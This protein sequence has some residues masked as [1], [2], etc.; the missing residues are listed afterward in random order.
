MDRYS[1]LNQSADLRTPMKLR[2]P[3]ED[4]R[5][6]PEVMAEQDLE[7]TLQLLAERARYLT[8]ASSASIGL[9][10]GTAVVCRASAGPL[11]LGLGSRLAVDSGLVGESLRQRNIMRID[12][13]EEDSRASAES[14]PELGIRS[15]MVA[16]LVREEEA[17]GVFE[18]LAERAYAFEER[19]VATLQR[20]SEMILT[21]LE[22]FD[23]ASRPLPEASSSKREQTPASET[24]PTVATGTAETSTARAIPASAGPEPQLVSVL[25]VQACQ[26]CGFPVSE[27]RT[28]CLDCE[29]AQ[30]S[31]QGATPAFLGHFSAVGEPGWLQSHLYTMGTLFI[32][33]LTVAL[34]VLKLR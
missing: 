8:G 30:S 2:L 4:G 18:L 13:V 33:A 22:Q 7:A 23:A 12:D 17:V 27:S 25:K 15:V 9:R 29:E 10:S 24:K 1:I 21:A 26:A 3:A 19:D 5:K 32:A 31:E 6:S 20:L 34:L 14:W 28:L 11:A 16:P